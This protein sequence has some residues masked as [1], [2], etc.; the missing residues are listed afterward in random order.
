MPSGLHC[1]RARGQGRGRDAPG[2]ASAGDVEDVDLR[3][4]VVLPLRGE[5]EPAAV[6]AP[7]GAALAALGRG[8]PPRRGARPRRARSRDRRPP[9]SRRRRARSPD[10]TTHLPSGERTGAPTRFIIQSDSCVTGCGAGW[11]PGP[12]RE[13]GGRQGKEEGGAGGRASLH[14]VISSGLDGGRTT[15][16]VR[17][18]RYDRRM[19]ERRVPGRA[20]ALLLAGLVALP[21]CGRGPSAERAPAGTPVVLISIDTLRADHVPAYGYGGVATPGL[22]R[23]RADSILFR[24]AW[25]PS[26]LTLPSHVTMLTGALPPEH[27][28][29]A[30]AGFTFRSETWPS[31]PLLLEPAGI[32]DGGGG[33]VVRAPR[34]DRA[35]PRLRFLR[36]RHRP[37]RARRLRGTSTARRRDG[38]PGPGL[39]IDAPRHALLLLPAPLRAAR[40]LRPAGAVPIALRLGLRRRD[41]ERGRHRGRLP[42][43]PAGAG[44]LRS[45]AAGPHLG[46]RRRAWGSRRGPALD[47]SLRRSAAGAAAPQ[48]AGRAPRRGDGGRARPARRHRADGDEPSRPDHSRHGLGAFAPRP[49]R[50]RGPAVVRGDP[51]PAAVPGL[52]RAAIA[53]GPPLASHPGPARR[54]VRPPA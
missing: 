4:L 9:S 2:L 21:G 54:A 36:G 37:A 28:V 30:N 3:D 42:R 24:N 5:G 50:G 25:A 6:G 44:P 23:L 29:R 1:G 48:A 51:V 52:E 26:P 22:D 7:V 35:G 13:A 20:P 47:P 19:A 43:S 38:L 39:D 53:R 34:R 14:R 10:R 17:D 33:L 46:P 16:I 27:G 18:P 40:A 31:L 41:R 11:G 32:C 15:S 8:E 49:S 45:R 12:R